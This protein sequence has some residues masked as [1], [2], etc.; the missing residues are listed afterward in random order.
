MGKGILLTLRKEIEMMQKHR[1]KKGQFYKCTKSATSAQKSLTCEEY[2]QKHIDPHQDHFPL[3]VGTEK[4]VQY[5]SLKT[6]T[7][8]GSR[9]ITGHSC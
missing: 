3:T 7:K 8:S 6:L 2:Q 4:N 1:I 9:R 5:L